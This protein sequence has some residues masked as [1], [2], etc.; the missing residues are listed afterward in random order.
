MVFDN[1]FTNEIVIKNTIRKIETLIF[2]NRNFQSLP[3]INLTIND[4]QLWSY[5]SNQYF[6]F[7]YYLFYVNYVPV[8]C[9]QVRSP[10]QFTMLD[11]YL[12]KK[13]L[14]LVEFLR[15][16]LASLFLRTENTLPPGA[17][18]TM[19]HLDM[20][21]TQRPTLLPWRVAVEEWPIPQPFFLYLSGFSN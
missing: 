17:A 19:S 18:G 4:R 16:D 14:N 3:S 1:N 2:T 20:P 11:L 7:I 10:P 13:L 5:D 21:P 9:S 12:L 15:A 8:L 6:V